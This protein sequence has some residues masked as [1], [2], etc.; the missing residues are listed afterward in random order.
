MT[1]API[2]SL[3]HP[4]VCGVEALEGALDGMPVGGWDGLEPTTVAD[5]SHELLRIEA[6]VKAHLLAAARVLDESGLAKA[7]GATST[8]AMLAGAFGSDRRAGDQLVRMGRALEQ[9]SVTEEALA[10]GR[11]GPAQAAIIADAIADLPADTT[12]EQKQSCEDT[13]IS[14]ADRLNLKDLKSRA[15]RIT[16]VFKPLPEVE[17]VENQTLERREKAA[18]GRSDFWIVNDGDGTCRGGFRIPEAQADM[19]TTAV[20]A[21]SAPRRDHLRDHP[22]AAAS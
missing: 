21:I 1:A 2:A 9:A 14:D 20:Q 12:V 13:L 17:A 10:Q 5:L 16:D 6:R 18:W 11:I 15:M 22:G 7:S 8:G 3:P 4:L 19:L